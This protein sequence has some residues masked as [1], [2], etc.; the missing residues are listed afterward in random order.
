ML[1]ALKIL[2]VF[3]REAPRRMILQDG[4]QIVKVAFDGG[5]R[6]SNSG[7]IIWTRLHLTISIIYRTIVHH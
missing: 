3:K 5:C 7:R 6:D 2:H 4:W 1:D